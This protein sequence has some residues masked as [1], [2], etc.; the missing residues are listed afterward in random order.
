MVDDDHDSDDI[1]EL[2][3]EMTS[4]VPP[5]P[6]QEADA[7]AAPEPPIRA[8]EPPPGAS[9]P[10]N[11]VGEPIPQEERESNPDISYERPS[12]PSN[13]PYV[14]EKKDEA[15]LVTPIKK[16][17]DTSDVYESA[18]PE[19]HGESSSA[20]EQISFL[21]QEMLVG[22]NLDE[23]TIVE[24]TDNMPPP[25]SVESVTGLEEIDESEAPVEEIDISEVEMPVEEI[26]V[27]EVEAPVEEIDISEVEMSVEEMEGE[28]ETSATQETG[29][30][31]QEG[32]PQEIKVAVETEEQEAD[33]G[34]PAA[35]FDEVQEEGQATPEEQVAEKIEGTEEISLDDAEEIAK[36]VNEEQGDK[37]APSPEEEDTA[38]EIDL[39]EAEEVPVPVVRHSNV[40][41]AIPLPVQRPPKMR[42]RRKRPSEWWAEIFDDDYLSLLP[43]TTPR[44]DRRQT[45]F[46]EKNINMS[47]GSLVL[48][49]GCGN[50]RHAVGMAKRGYRIVGVDLS[51]PMLA[52][53]GEL[54]QEEDQ[55]INFI[56]GD[57][58][59]LGFEQTFDAVYCVGTSFG[60]FDDATNIRVIEGIARALKPGAPF[61]L[62][63]VNRDNVIAAQPNLT[64]FE[65]SGAICMEETSF[66]YINSRLYVTRQLII[67]AEGKQRQVKHD[68][69]M[70]LYSLH[71]LGTILHKAGFAVSK[72]GGHQSTPGSFFGADSAKI[73]IT[74]GRRK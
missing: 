67:G 74:A 15:V 70:R 34:T 47:K 32:T 26:D 21:E 48:D 64:W 62:E 37:N 18:M 13:L 27:S 30:L 44:D 68:M 46:I 22:E 29:T 65:G 25:A 9:S 36:S 57:M 35:V 33:L 16:L 50:G 42:R 7:A 10:F 31:E 40:G 19:S 28:E 39:A 12:R 53:A 72:V 38:V 17:R 63:V 60:Y 73:I 14:P 52:R 3:E 49:L 20:D 4:I 58:R 45:D 55:K 11:L 43:R 8:S 56:H 2:T 61:L 71:E 24:E 59:D 69:S 41:P 23:E 6:D 5:S 54:A 66:N 1:F 51:L